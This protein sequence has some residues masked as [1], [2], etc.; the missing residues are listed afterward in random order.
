MDRKKHQCKYRINAVEKTSDTLSSGAG[1]SLFVRYLENIPIYP[2][3]ERLFGGMRKEHEGAGEEN[4]RSFA[5]PSSA[6]HSIRM[7]RCC[8]SL[9]GR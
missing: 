3:I 2:L 6:A 1:F 7:A 5:G 8:S 4:G 9:S